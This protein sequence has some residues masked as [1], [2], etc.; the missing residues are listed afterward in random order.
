MRIWWGCSRVRCWG[1]RAAR[2]VP[3]VQC[4]RDEG[5][6]LANACSRVPE[7]M[8]ASITRDKTH[9]RNLISQPAIPYTPFRD[10]FTPRPHPIP[11]PDSFWASVSL[12]LS[13]PRARARAACHCAPAPPGGA[14]PASRRQATPGRSDPRQRRPR[15]HNRD[16]LHALSALHGS[17]AARHGGRSCHGA[18]AR[19]ARSGSPPTRPSAPGSGCG[20]VL[21][22]F[23]RRLVV[24]LPLPRERRAAGQRARRATR[25][26]GRGGGRAARAARRAGGLQRL[27]QERAGGALHARGGGALPARRSGRQP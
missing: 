23:L 6:R 8:T 12:T 21:L 25:R 15:Q 22:L 1:A 19:S 2:P 16:D 14:L 24:P 10:H 3:C 13:C 27:P 9:I 11:K 20:R 17:R 18:T 4:V 26:R 7:T 5:E